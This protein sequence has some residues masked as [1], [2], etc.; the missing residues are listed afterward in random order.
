MIEVFQDISRYHA[1]NIVESVLT[2]GKIIFKDGGYSFAPD[3]A[4][5]PYNLLDQNTD[6]PRIVPLIGEIHPRLALQNLIEIEITSCLYLNENDASGEIEVRSI[7]KGIGSSIHIREECPLIRWNEKYED[8]RYFDVVDVQHVFTEGRLK[9][10]FSAMLA[11][12]LCESEMF[13][14]LLHLNVSGT[15]DT[16][17]YLHNPRLRG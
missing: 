11:E 2:V 1:A 9:N 12:S 3:N 14:P 5:S 8:H 6:T 10:S 16:E 13:L 4:L 7:H 17:D 15:Y